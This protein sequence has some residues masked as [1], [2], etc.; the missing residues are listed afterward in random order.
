MIDLSAQDSGSSMLGGDFSRAIG[1]GVV[2]NQDL[3]EAWF[4]RAGVC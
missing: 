4:L 3:C 2:V 1:T